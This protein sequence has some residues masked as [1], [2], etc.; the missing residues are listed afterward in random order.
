MQENNFVSIK[1]WATEDRPR[2]K[3]I[4]KGANSL[5]NAELLAILINT[6]TANRSALDIA[7]DVM[8]MSSQN[9]IELSKH[10][11]EDFKKI[12]GLGE[13]KSITLM[14]ALELG[15]R[16]QLSAA[17]EKP[18]ITNSKDAFEILTP[19]FIGN[20]TE[21]FYV[22]FLMQNLRI[23]SIEK[24]SAGG[25]T[26]T[27]VDRRTIFRRAL[28]LKLV[29]SIILAHNHPSGNLAPSNA[30]KLIT[31]KMVEAGGFLDI[32]IFDHIIICANQYYSFRDNGLITKM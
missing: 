13:K 32:N 28:E 24:V 26:A 30:D 7:K 14:A 23:L 16:R 25:I 8:N 1:N 5:S 31:N 20:V 29:T 11:F 18:K 22:I 17:L 6:G 27:V 12:K 10:T 15:K 19:Y 9:L 2:E 21:E 3:M 4:E